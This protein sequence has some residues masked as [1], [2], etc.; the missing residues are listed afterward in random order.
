MTEEIFE[1]PEDTSGGIK[2][3]SP[4]TGEVILDTT[5]LSTIKLT[6]LTNG[7]IPYHVSDAAGLA[8]GPTKTDVDDAVNKR[9]QVVADETARLA[10]SNLVGRFALQADTQRLYIQKA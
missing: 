9:V 6:N 8:D 3:S 1:W 7:K 2:P 10:L 5:S 4:I